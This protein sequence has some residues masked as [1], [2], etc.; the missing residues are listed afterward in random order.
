MDLVINAIAT[1]LGPVFTAHGFAGWD[2]QLFG[3][4]IE[5][6]RLGAWKTLAVQL[7][8]YA[9]RP[10]D[11][12]LAQARAARATGGASGEARS[13]MRFYAT[14][15]L[16]G[17]VVKRCA[18]VNEIR[19]VR[20]SGVSDVFGILQRERTDEFRASFSAKYPALYKE[21]GFSTPLTWP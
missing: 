11:G 3:D 4:R 15:E 17:V 1:T 16:E 14:T 2:L 8:L 7:A 12:V 19:F 18:G 5:A 13:G 9:G 10:V 6:Y 20:R 21:E